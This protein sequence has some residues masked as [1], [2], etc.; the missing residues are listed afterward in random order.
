MEWR[1]SLP[2]PGVYHSGI[3]GP[4][5]VGEDS[6]GKRIVKYSIGDSSGHRHF[7]YDFLSLK[8]EDRDSRVSAVADNSLVQIFS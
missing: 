7:C 4:A 6:V 5:V 8:I 2:S 3:V 1:T